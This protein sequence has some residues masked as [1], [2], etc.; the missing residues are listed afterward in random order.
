MASATTL[1]W[2]CSLTVWWSFIWRSV[3]YGFAGGFVLGAIGGFIAGFTGHLDQARIYGAVAGYLA[4]LILS[5]LAM[6]QALEGNLA[7]LVAASQ[8]REA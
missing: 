4:G 3:I 1:D 5:T 7:L 8:T 6:K 2:K